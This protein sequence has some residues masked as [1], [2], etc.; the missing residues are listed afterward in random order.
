MFLLVISD[1]WRSKIEIN[2]KIL[3]RRP[4]RVN[5]SRVPYSQNKTIK[6]YTDKIWC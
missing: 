5:K 2:Q 4:E 3:N 6:V 1:C